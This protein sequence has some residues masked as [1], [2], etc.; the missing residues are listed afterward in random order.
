[1]KQASYSNDGSKKQSNDFL[2]EEGPGQDFL[3]EQQEL[4]L[5]L[6]EQ[7]L[8]LGLNRNKEDLKISVDDLPDETDLAT[9]VINQEVSFNIRKREIEKLRQINMAL[10]RIKNNDY[11]FCEECGEF[12]GRK[13]LKNQPWTDLCITHAEEREREEISFGRG[14]GR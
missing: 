7:I 6:K 9:S 5:N 10:I 12:I 1:M 11:G 4:L 2:D 8:S 13:R 3:A 14:P